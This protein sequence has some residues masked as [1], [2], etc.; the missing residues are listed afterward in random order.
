LWRALGSAA[1]DHRGVRLALET[2]REF[3]GWAVLEDGRG[4]RFPSF[5][6]FCK[7]PPPYGLG[8]TR[9]QVEEWAALFAWARTPQAQAEDPEV[10]QIVGHG[11]D[12]R[13]ARVRKNQGDNVTLVRGNRAEYLVRRLKRDAPEIARQLADGTFRSARAAA[14]AAGIINRPTALDRLRQAWRRATP[15]ERRGF[16]QEIGGD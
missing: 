14:L 15:E 3:R 6:A 5:E 7:A 13:S 2:F 11:G 8:V 16:L 12:R 10:K 9:R 4:Q 1:G